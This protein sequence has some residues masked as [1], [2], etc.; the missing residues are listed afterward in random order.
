MQKKK[1][2]I[3]EHEQLA[4]DIFRLKLAGDIG[5]RPGQFVQVGV[6]STL[7]PF[8]NRPFS[9]H[10]CTESSLTLLYRVVGRGTRLLAQRPKGAILSVVGPLGNGFPRTKKRQA[11]L[12][13]GGIGVAPLYYLLHTLRAEGKDVSFLYG[14]KTAAEIVLE[15]EFRSLV[16]EFHL[17]TEDGSA[18]KQGFVT[19][20]LPQV[21]AEKQADIFACGPSAMLRAVAKIATQMDLTCF[22]SLE[23]EMACGVGACL[24]CVVTGADGNYRRVCTDGPVFAAGEVFSFDS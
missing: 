21:L 24:G 13:A 15:N 6:A 3:L 7:E 18:G 23:A 2:E 16:Q 1:M 10:N 22:V 9:V 17:T 4:D 11:V 8:L 19:E 12:V 14:T 5:A 20:L